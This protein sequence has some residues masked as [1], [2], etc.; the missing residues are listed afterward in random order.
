M[1]ALEE[2]LALQATDAKERGNKA[3]EAARATLAALGLPGYLDASEGSG[4]GVP[5]ALWE[6]IRKTQIAGG[7]AELERLFR[8]N[9]AAGEEARATL[10]RVLQT[11]DDEAAGDA[12]CRRQFGERWTA[13]P[14]DVI[15]AEIRGEAAKYSKVAEAAAASDALVSGKLAA[16]REVLTTLGQTKPALDAS[17]PAGFGAAAAA[18]GSAADAIRGQLKEALAQ[19]QG[20]HDERPKLAAAIKE[21]FERHAAVSAFLTAINTAT[22]TA[23]AAAAASGAAT[24][25]E[26]ADIS[27]ITERLLTTHTAATKRA[28]EDNMAAAGSALETIKAL[29]AR[30]AEV[31]SQDERTVG[32]ERALQRLA[33][34]VERFEELKSNLKEGEQFYRDLKAQADRLLVTAQDMAAA[35]G[36][37]QRELMMNIRA[38]AEA[39]E[40][41]RTDAELAGRMAAAHIGAGGASG[42]AAP[43]AAGA[44]AYPSTA[45]WSGAAA[46]GSARGGAVAVAVP[47]PGGPGGA[48]GPMVP[49][50][51]NP[52]DAF[53]PESNP[54]SPLR[55]SAPGAGGFL[56]TPAAHGGRNPTAAPY[57]PYGPGSAAA[58]PVAAAPAPYAGGGYAAGGAYGHPSY[59]PAA[60]AAPA[61]GGHYA[62]AP[63]AAAG[64]APSSQ[65]QQLLNMGF[66]HAD[67][68]RALAATRND[69]GAAVSMLLDGSGSRV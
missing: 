30:F 20:L 9:T 6:R 12:S 29:H 48:P 66:S 58:A 10:A 23:A 43:A 26:P 59:A 3:A 61:Y 21:R 39:D 52:F 22:N 15:A 63:A 54:S 32:R 24:A 2:Q 1:T 62:A 46:P 7:L 68:E 18:S 27:T 47:L 60:S 50:S 45:A 41:S 37:Q 5:P 19:L 36:L 8:G 4:A 42:A 13:A 67:A 65:V 69:V 64:P 35:R 51:Y 28:F 38:A 34:G 56:P 57:H 16:H 25:A 31:R 49:R 44:P 11:L 53:N 33:D 55:D 14:S 17:I 40:R